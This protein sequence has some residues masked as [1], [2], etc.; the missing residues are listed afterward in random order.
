M[1]KSAFISHA[2]VLLNVVKFA[3]VTL[4][5]VGVRAVLSFVTRI[6]QKKFAYFLNK[7]SCTFATSG[8]KL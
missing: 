2:T 5:V 8:M 7:N 1:R 4:G 3:G 6:G